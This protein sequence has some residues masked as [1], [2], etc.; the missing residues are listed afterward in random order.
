[1]KEEKTMNII[2]WS[3][4]EN[5]FDDFFYPTRW[6]RHL[7]NW[8][9]VADVYDKADHL[10]I[11]AELPGVDKKDIVIDVKDG[12]LTLSG[13]RSYDNETKEESYF[14]KERAY[15][16]FERSFTLPTHVDAEKI[17]AE[18]KDGLLTIE[19][20]KPEKHRPKKITIH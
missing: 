2:K 18:F 8:N 14:R 12:V 5:V 13:E 16:K 11:K 3:P 4:I 15:G 10:V 7:W 9:P 1:M 17:K 19:I 6:D 20:P